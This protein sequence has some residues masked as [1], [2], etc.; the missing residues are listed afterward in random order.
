MTL[1]PVL[2]DGE[3]Q[4]SESPL[5]TFRPVNPTT[6]TVLDDEYPTSNWSE[7][8]RAISAAV[9]AVD[10]LRSVTPDQIATFL[11]TYAA[12]IEARAAEL[13]E[14]A[15]TETALPREPRLKSV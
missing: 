12:N 14:L 8:E 13:V 15:Y 6:K 3:W 5:S 2:I 10:E 9:R 7:I 4:P 11:E 1:Q